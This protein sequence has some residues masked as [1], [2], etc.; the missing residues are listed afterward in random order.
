MRSCSSAVSVGSFSK[1]DLANV[2]VKFPLIVLSVTS[3]HGPASRGRG[4]A[5]LLTYPIYRSQSDTV[6]YP[7]AIPSHPFSLSHPALLFDVQERASVRSCAVISSK[8]PLLCGTAATGSTLR[9]RGA[10]RRDWLASAVPALICVRNRLASCTPL[11]TGVVLSHT[12]TSGHSTQEDPR[13]VLRTSA[14]ENTELEPLVKPPE[15]RM[16]ACGNVH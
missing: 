1:S 7:A 16:V 4:D 10:A 15:N 6:A 12:E 14:V 8:G 3:T 9:H 13:P 2:R 5:Y 11:H